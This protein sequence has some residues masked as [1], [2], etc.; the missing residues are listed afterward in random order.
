MP[1][2]TPNAN[3]NLE[4]IAQQFG[5][6]PA[7]DLRIRDGNLE[8]KSGVTAAAGKLWDRLSN[9]RH[10]SNVQAEQVLINA[11]KNSSGGEDPD[12]AAKTRIADTVRGNG[13]TVA[14][15]VRDLDT[16]AKAVVAQRAAVAQAQ[17][18][19][20]LEKQL[21]RVAN[22]QN[23]GAVLKDSRA[24]IGIE[25]DNPAL[26]VHPRAGEELFNAVNNNPNLSPAA[27]QSI[28][29]EVTRVAV[30]E[31]GNRAGTADAHLRE[32]GVHKQFV[33]ANLDHLS[34]ATFASI[35]Q[36]M[37][38]NPGV[39]QLSGQIQAATPLNAP[40]IR[41]LGTA[42]ANVMTQ[43]L[44][45]PE[46]YSPELRETLAV[47][48]AS[49][50]AVGELK[51]NTQ[52]TGNKAVT[53]TFILGS[54]N[55]T[56]GGQLQDQAQNNGQLTAAAM[57]CQ[58]FQATHGAA[59]GSGQA[60][61]GQDPANFADY[62]ALVAQAGGADVLQTEVN[63]AFCK[64][65]IATSGLEAQPV[66]DALKTNPALTPDQRTQAILTVTEESS[67]Q[68]TLGSGHG[69]ELGRSTSGWT[70]FATA[71]TSDALQGYANGVQ[72]RVVQHIS[73]MDTSDI[74]QGDVVRRMDSEIQDATLQNGAQ[75]TAAYQELGEATIQAIT[76]E[77]ASIENDPKAKAVMNAIGKG[78]EKASREN[79]ALC[80]NA[81]GVPVY[82]P[83]QNAQ[84]I[85][86]GAIFLR[87]VNPA[88]STAGEKLVN[89]GANDPPTNAQQKI[90]GQL[91]K[92]AAILGMT[93]DNFVDSAAVAV[94]KEQDH[95]VKKMLEGDQQLK[96]G[97][98]EFM[99][100]VAGQPDGNQVAQNAPA[101][102][103]AVVQPVNNAASPPVAGNIVVAPLVQNPAVPL[104]QPAPLVQNPVVPLQ[105]PA[106]PA[107]DHA[108]V[109]ADLGDLHQAP[110]DFSERIKQFGQK[111]SPEELQ[112]VASGKKV[113]YDAGPKVAKDAHIVP[114]QAAK[115]PA[116]V[117][118]Q[119]APAFRQS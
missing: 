11:Y 2:I 117:V 20:I 5:N 44:A 3:T 109:A 61:P 34:Q 113:D 41:Q 73:T 106:P 85:R 9:N 31:S 104:Q 78:A 38:Q 108:K 16:Q 23:M 95:V 29:L 36:Q 56:F 111:A 17:A 22:G 99:G 114:K 67:R 64:L 43:E 8:A 105:Q 30:A 71:A 19:T 47:I 25:A 81:G 37:L 118:K 60:P 10:D 101:V 75:I 62:A 79:P 53:N 107:N 92:K 74:V 42:M 119:S 83:E 93:Y 27:K 65:E 103:V 98:K 21:D 24:V 89:P 91:M 48:H 39:Q 1:S 13:G 115:D 49:G 46:N 35:H 66:Y 96:A 100:K 84:R 70:G 6:S 14:D 7:R 102:H 28:L 57:A 26:N 90:Q 52:A 112:T 58:S 97:Y 45:K 77:Y 68:Q 59:I 12:A 18:V 63:K 55:A 76:E 82:T 50:Q 32:D 40:E 110:K 116:P 87:A 51:P 15:L 88:L 54:V 33:K 72:Q 4:D 94:N 69:D 86:Q 80:N